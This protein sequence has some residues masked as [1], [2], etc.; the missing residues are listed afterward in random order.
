MLVEVG[1]ERSRAGRVDRG[2]ETLVEG[3]GVGVIESLSEGVVGEFA[4]FQLQNS[5]NLLVKLVRYGDVSAHEA[6]AYANGGLH[7]LVY[8]VLVMTSPSSSVK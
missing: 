2:T 5:C 7:L 1:S 8:L 6:R 4:L 3:D